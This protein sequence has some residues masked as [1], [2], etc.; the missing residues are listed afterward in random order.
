MG[1]NR[2]NPN[3]EDSG[4]YL[5]QDDLRG[6]GDAGRQRDT[7]SARDYGASRQ[8]RE[9]W[10]G[11][12]RG[13][14]GFGEERGY[15][16]HGGRGYQGQE[17]YRGDRGRQGDGFRR[18]RGQGYQDRS[19]GEDRPRGDFG[20]AG[21]YGQGERQGQRFSHQ[22]HHEGSGYGPYGQRGQAH[23]EGAYGHQ[24]GGDTS[25]RGS[26]QGGYGYQASDYDYEDRGFM[27]R[28]G[29]E[30]RRWFG[31][32]R[33]QRRREMDQR[34][35]E[36]QGGGGGQGGQNWGGGQSNRD[37]RDE[38]EARYPGGIRGYS[39]QRGPTFQ[40]GEWIGTGSGWARGTDEDDY[41]SWRRQQIE[42]LD[43]DYDEYRRENRQRFHSEFE[44]WRTERQGQRGALRS[45]RE[46]MEVVGA[47]GEH[48]GTVD[49]VLGDRIL[50]T[51]SDSN[52][53]GKHHSI[54][55]RWI[56]TVDEKVTIRKTAQE[57]IAAWREEAEQDDSNA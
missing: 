42:S 54:P 9:D 41:G 57:A 35:D 40:D 1:D 10:P 11:G 46:H 12:E 34:Y 30:V 37:D 22:E 19:L 4:S 18:D 6:G 8:G 5:T 16:D 47:D 26:Q 14:R 25:H 56:Q 38:S 27:A 44:N 32:D 43:R 17:A 2:Y 50:L 39:N 53:G 28:A 31:D 33:A 20:G 3:Q 51:K 55:S 21:N 24:G 23:S 49:H 52:A 45:V 29:D 48:V 7:S 13:S 15:G 36:R